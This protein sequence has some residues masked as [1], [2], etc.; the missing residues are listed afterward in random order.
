M[1]FDYG[2]R[3]LDVI[4]EYNPKNYTFV[5]LPNATRAG[6]NK[7]FNNDIGVIEEIYTRARYELSEECFTNI[8]WVNYD[9]NSES[10][11]RITSY[12]D[13]L[14]T[15]RFHS[16]ISALAQCIP[17]LVVGWSHKYHETLADFGLEKYA[18]DFGYLDMSLIP[19]LKELIDKNEEIRNQML[20][21]LNVVKQE[22]ARQFE[23]L[24]DFFVEQ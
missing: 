6:L 18:I 10:I 13:V 24:E 5:F 11:R 12:A 9:I 17:C 8:L 23:Y 16:M 20:A 15:S 1:D 19:L 3:F 2:K 4:M 7:A 14:V 22:A 21:S